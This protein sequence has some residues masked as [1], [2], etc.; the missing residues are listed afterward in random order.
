MRLLQRFWYYAHRL[1]H[2]VFHALAVFLS[3]IQHPRGLSGGHLPELTLVSQHLLRP[4][5]LDDLEVLLER[6]TVGGIDR[7][8]LMRQRPADAMSLLCHD[9]DPAPLI[10]SG[11]T[12]VGTAACHMVQHRNVLGDPDWIGSR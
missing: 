6:R 7:I 1:Q 4:G 5:F 8:V 2:P 10:A 12:G 11:K 3:G 9:V